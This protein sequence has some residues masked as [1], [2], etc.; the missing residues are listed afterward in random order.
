MPR[1]EKERF[2]CD[3]SYAIKSKD[4]LYYCGLKVWD[5][6]VRKA[7]LYHDDKHAENVRKEYPD[8]DTIIVKVRTEEI[9]D[10]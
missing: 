9:L 5:R 4:G 2:T 1:L 10:D 7:K 8:I 6:Q 3:I